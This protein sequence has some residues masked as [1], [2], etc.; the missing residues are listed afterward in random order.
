M[1]AVI[2]SSGEGNRLRPLTCSAPL[3]MLP[4]MGMPIVEHTFRLLKRHNINSV[5]ISSYYLSEEVKN[6]FSNIKEERVSF[7]HKQSFENF[8]ADDDTVLISDSILTDINFE[9]VISFFNHAKSNVFVTKSAASS[10]EYGSLHTNGSLITSYTRCPDFAH[11]TGAAFTGI[12]VIKKGTR[13]LDCSD[14]TTLI[15][16]LVEEKEPLYAYNTQCYVCNVSDFESYHKVCRDFMDKKIM[17]PFPCDEKAPSVWV[18]KD[19]TVMQGSVIVPP[20]YIGSG[21]MISKGARIEAYT[22]IG[23]NVSVDCFAGIKR[24]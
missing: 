14:L 15:Q 12:A 5:T 22:Q 18:D 20:V 3:C 8:F 21:S 16:K 11:P 4:V 7:T 1:K 19:A 10:Y 23:E 2:I 17:L 13:V 6:H 9:D 24:S